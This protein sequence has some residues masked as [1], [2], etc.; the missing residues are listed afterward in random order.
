MLVKFLAPAAVT[1]LILAA[2]V[3]PAP[4]AAQQ[5]ALATDSSFIQ[6]AA[7]FG[8]LQVKLGRLA[9]EKGSDSV[10]R[11]FGQRMVAEYSKANEEFAAAAK[12]AAYP[13]PVL[14][15]Q[16]KLLYEKVS[17]MGR[18]SF[19]KGYM[20]EMVND[21]AEAARLFQQEAERGRVESLK[22]LAASMLPMVQQQLAVATQAAG[23]VGADIISAA[24]Q[25]R[26][27]P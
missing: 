14:L 2:T 21:H 3:S 18:S 15:R 13:A 5:A 16:D 20:T 17:R 8:L 22:Q 10:V 26:R 19:D 23:S 9:A 7:S 6:T 12:Q 1:G 24:A 11:N 4:A 25:A 27:G